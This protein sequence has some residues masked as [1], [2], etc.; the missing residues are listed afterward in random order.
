M[1]IDNSRREQIYYSLRND[2]AISY[3]NPRYGLEGGDFISNFG[4][5]GR[6]PDGDILF[7]GVGFNG[8]SDKFATT[9]LDHIGFC[10]YGDDIEVVFDE[11]FQGD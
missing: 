3:Q 1:K 5:L 4:Q 8:R 10:D 2:F 11:C 6:L 9:T 7:Y